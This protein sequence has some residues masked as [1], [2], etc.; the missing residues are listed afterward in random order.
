LHAF[1]NCLAVKK[2]VVTST[3]AI[4]ALWLSRLRQSVRDCAMV[5]L[6]VCR[7]WC[8]GASSGD[9]GFGEAH[10][11]SIAG[12]PTQRESVCLERV[13]YFRSADIPRHSVKVIPAYA[14]IQ[15]V[16]QIW[17]PAYAGI[18]FKLCIQ[19]QRKAFNIHNTL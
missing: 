3:T 1:E 7:G 19:A 6:R 8:D 18:T 12:Q 9:A 14:G 11:R 17:I 2:W 15:A 16:P 5:D 4:V 13:M 10:R